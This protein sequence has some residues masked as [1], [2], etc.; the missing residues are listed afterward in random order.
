MKVIENRE[1]QATLKS[2]HFGVSQEP[3]SNETPQLSRTEAM[4]AQSFELT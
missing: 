1:A 3:L 4:A 2:K